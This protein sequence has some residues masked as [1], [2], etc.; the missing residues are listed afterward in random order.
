MS[1][2]AKALIDHGIEVEVLFLQKSDA[3]DL[4]EDID[5]KKVVLGYPIYYFYHMSKWVR[6]WQL[7]KLAA[8]F[9]SVLFYFVWGAPSAI[10]R[11]RA[12]LVYLNSSVLP[13]WLIVSKF[14]KRKTVVHVREAVSGGHTG[15]RRW[16]LSKL[17]L[18][19]ADR[20]IFISRH[21]MSRMRAKESRRVHL[22]YNYEPAVK[23][24]GEQEKIYDF[25][26]LGGESYIKGWPLIRELLKRNSSASFL[27]VGVYSDAV[28]TE[29]RNNPRIHFIGPSKSIHKHIS[30]SRF[31]ISPFLEP[32]FSRPVVEAYACGTVP[33]A[34][35]LEGTEEQ[36]N[37]QSGFLFERD[38]PYAFYE[39]IERCLS[40]SDSEYKKMVCSG[41]LLFEE[42]F[43][44]HNERKIISAIVSLRKEGGCNY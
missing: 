31:L 12:D 1:Y 6:C 37:D 18:N 28:R 24:D 41:K 32:H 30:A 21:N 14:L 13:E 9:L 7:H 2:L 39:V 5:C 26:Y 35:N 44:S 23:V 8:Q 27:L 15:L 17:I 11:S 19:L 10:I 33:I 4:F 36:I 34:T 29:F 22:I 25:I 38:N 43:S 40:M 42:R 20:V 16:L 3:V